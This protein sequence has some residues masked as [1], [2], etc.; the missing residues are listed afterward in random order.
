M[1]RRQAG[2]ERSGPE[3]DDIDRG[4]E[5]GQEDDFGGGEDPAGGWGDGVVVGGRSLV[6]Q[7]SAGAADAVFGAIRAETQYSVAVVKLFRAR[8]LATAPTTN[9]HP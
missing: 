9:G 5:H 7:L 2:L 1:Q 6:E 3:V 8:S 4:E